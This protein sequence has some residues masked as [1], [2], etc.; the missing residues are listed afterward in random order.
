MIDHKEIRAALDQ[1]L[2]TSAQIAA[3]QAA[4]SRTIDTFKAA[5]KQAVEE[6]VTGPSTLPQGAAE[7]RR[8]HRSGVPSRIASDP[9]LEA[10]IRAR[11]GHMTFAQLL[12]EVATSFPPRRQ[13]SMSALSRWWK[14]NRQISG[15]PT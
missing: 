5:L 10:F 11:I 4:N 9:E 2:Q 13:T 8:A 1:A 12:S 3:L 6:P 7:H 15:D 14:A